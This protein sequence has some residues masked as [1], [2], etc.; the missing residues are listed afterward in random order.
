MLRA[1]DGDT[2]RVEEFLSWLRGVFQGISGD[3]PVLIVS[4]SIGLTPLVRQLAIPDRFNYLNP[5]RLGP[6]NRETSV[7]CFEQLARTTPLSVADGVAQA[8]YDA[9]G[10]GIPH[11]V[12]SFF[13][14]LRDFAVMENRDRV[15][16]ADVKRVYRTG[17][18]GPSGQNDLAHFSCT[19]L[20]TGG[21]RAS[22]IT[23]FLL[24]TARGTLRESTPDE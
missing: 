3:S 6:W 5:F 20:E 21:R 11:H 16:V 2:S 24:L 23:T 19:R 15:T 13:V 4:G 8:V 12:Q 1:D 22:A 17:L 10:I 14:R 9:L 18:L 7:A